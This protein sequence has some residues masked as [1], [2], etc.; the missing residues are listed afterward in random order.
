[1]YLCKTSKTHNIFHR[2]PHNNNSFADAPEAAHARDYH[3]RAIAV[4]VR[5]AVLQHQPAADR[6]PVRA[7][8]VGTGRASLPDV[9]LR[10]LRERGRVLVVY[11]RH[12]HKQVSLLAFFSF[13]EGID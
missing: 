2:Q 9:R 8:A 11:G 5:P 3:V 7:P 10:L 13:L 1:M 6:A 12:Y 4:R